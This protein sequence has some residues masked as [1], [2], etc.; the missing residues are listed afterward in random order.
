M[1]PRAAPW[2]CMSLQN[3]RWR[4]PQ[5]Q[6]ATLTHI[7]H[8]S[9]PCFCG[10]KGGK[11]R[12]TTPDRCVREFEHG[13][14]NRLIWEGTDERRADE[15]LVSALATQNLRDAVL[16]AQERLLVHLVEQT[17]FACPRTESL[18]IYEALLLRSDVAYLDHDQRV[19]VC[20]ASGKEDVC[21]KLARCALH[22]ITE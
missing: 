7:A 16:L 17:A 12:L 2:E 11:G 5:V 4:R 15:P 18:K 9:A 13:L 14:A 10:W 19:L 8:I 3:R 1:R 22:T 21:V 20:R 6:R